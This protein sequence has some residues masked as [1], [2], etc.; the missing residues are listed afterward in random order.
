MLNRRTAYITGHSL[1]FF[2]LPLASLMVYDYGVDCGEIENYA[3][4]GYCF[5]I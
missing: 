4:F 1:L 2:F 5:R 3:L